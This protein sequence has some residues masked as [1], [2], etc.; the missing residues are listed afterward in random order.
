[1]N[2]MIVDGQEFVL[3][4]KDKFEIMNLPTDNN[5]DVDTSDGSINNLSFECC[6]ETDSD[7]FVFSVLA[8]EKDGELTAND[9]ASITWTNKRVPRA[10]QEEQY[11][12]NLSWI[13]S[14]AHESNR[15]N[16]KEFPSE[17]NQYGFRVVQE[18]VKKVID[19]GWVR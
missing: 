9:M 4:P 14:L 7:L 17:I 6:S 16:I 2:T 11:W 3:V 1:M 5:E 10:E 12:D 19:L 8:D 13:V 15:S 18:L